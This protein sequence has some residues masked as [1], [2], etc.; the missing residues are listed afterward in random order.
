MEPMRASQ[1]TLRAWRVNTIQSTCIRTP[2]PRATAPPISSWSP[3]REGSWLENGRAS[4]G[5]QT[6]SQP[7]S[8]MA[9]SEPAAAV[10]ARPRE[11]RSA[12]SARGR[13]G[14]IRI[15]VLARIT[16]RHYICDELPDLFGREDRLEGR[17]RRKAARDPRVEVAGLEVLPA[18]QPGRPRDSPFPAVAVPGTALLEQPPPLGDR[19]G[20]AEVE[21]GSGGHRRGPAHPRP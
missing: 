18:T 4:G 14:R 13:I 8:R 12:A 10:E 5:A 2:R 21:R 9:A 11:Q 3:G 19:G 7:L 17:H 16:Q 1:S 20:I 6:W 15:S